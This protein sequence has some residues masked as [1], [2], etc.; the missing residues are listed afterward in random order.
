MTEL[1][2][3][4]I[5]KSLPAHIQ[6]LKNSPFNFAGE[7]INVKTLLSMS[8]EYAQKNKLSTAFTEQKVYKDFFRFLEEFKTTDRIST[9]TFPKDFSKIVDELIE[10]KL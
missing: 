5:I 4:N 10:S 8:K 3:Q 7:T 1:K 6:M 2:K 9:Y